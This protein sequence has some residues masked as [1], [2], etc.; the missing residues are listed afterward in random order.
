MSTNTQFLKGIYINIL[1]KNNVLITITYHI[2][3]VHVICQAF[4]SNN[5][6]NFFYYLH[7]V[8]CF[9]MSILYTILLK[10][11]NSLFSS[12]P[13]SVPRFSTTRWHLPPGLYDTH[14]FS[15]FSLKYGLFYNNALKIND[16]TFKK[17]KLFLMALQINR[18]R[19]KWL[20][21]VHVSSLISRF[22]IT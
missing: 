21:G 12:V 9:K 11:M 19:D 14:T 20:L 5:I 7:L 16:N 8:S 3:V 13:F 2:K 6:D 4:I 17:L 10:K 1:A 15:S 22:Q 18:T